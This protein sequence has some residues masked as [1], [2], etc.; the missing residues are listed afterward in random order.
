MSVDL[1]KYRNGAAWAQRIERAG[2]PC[3]HLG[4]RLRAVAVP[5]CCGSAVRVQVF[6]CGVHHRCS[7]DVEISADGAAA[8]GVPPF[9]G[10]RTCPD[11]VAGVADSS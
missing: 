11:W 4:R 2:Q 3:K 10:C 8:A 5:G 6:A 7:T 9:Q 1:S